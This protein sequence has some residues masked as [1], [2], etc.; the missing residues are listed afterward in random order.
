MAIFL[1]LGV[2][3][4]TIETKIIFFYGLKIWTI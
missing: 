4:W 3:S 2:L 1:Q